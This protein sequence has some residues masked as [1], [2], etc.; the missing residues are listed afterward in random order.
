MVFGIKLKCFQFVKQ[1]Q[2]QNQLGTNSNDEHSV[3]TVCKKCG[4]DI[5]K[6]DNLYTKTTIDMELLL[7][8]ETFVSCQQFL[9]DFNTCFKCNKNLIICNIKSDIVPFKIDFI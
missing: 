5:I 3:I 9:S 7:T 6:K 4:N 2:Y 1:T 8:K